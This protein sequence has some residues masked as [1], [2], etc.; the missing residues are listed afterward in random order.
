MR[1][2]VEC[3]ASEALEKEDGSV[4]EEPELKRFIESIESVRSFTGFCYKK[5]VTTDASVPIALVKDDF[6]ADGLKFQLKSD[7]LH[8]VDSQTSDEP[9]PRSNAFDI[10]MQPKR[11]RFLEDVPV[12]DPN[13]Q[14][15]VNAG[16]LAYFANIK[17]GY[18]D[19]STEK[20]LKTLAKT[21]RDILCFVHGQWGSLFRQSQGKLGMKTIVGVRCWFF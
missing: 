16:L 19:G 1:R 9:K 5:F 15:Q 12:K 14:Q 11:P 3:I 4:I 13:L 8:G 7:I 21:L 2:F 20:E 10:I 6:E 18:V 17:L